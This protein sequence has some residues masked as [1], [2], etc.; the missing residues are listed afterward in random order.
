[1]VESEMTLPEM[2]N[3]IKGGA[4]KVKETLDKGDKEAAWKAYSEDMNDIVRIETWESSKHIIL[5][6][7]MDKIEKN[8]TDDLY[9]LLYN[10]ANKQRIKNKLT[11]IIQL[12]NNCHGVL[13]NIN[14][15]SS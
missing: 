4:R 2:L 15:Q 12:V 3:T 6:D 5:K 14:R 10:Q 11:Y 8:I 1:M 7:L 13:S 9:G